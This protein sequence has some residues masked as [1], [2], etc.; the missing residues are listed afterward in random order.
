MC[1]YCHILYNVHSDTGE[2]GGS[3]PY[4]T[5]TVSGEPQRV[6]PQR[7]QRT[8]ELGEGDLLLLIHHQG[9]AAMLS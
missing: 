5:L 8:P 4:S 6:Q 1:D 3:P 2:H 9:L 7:V